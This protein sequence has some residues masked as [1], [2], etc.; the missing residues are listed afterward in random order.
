MRTAGNP[1]VLQTAL[2]VE[3]GS[4]RFQGDDAVSPFHAGNFSKGASF[5]FGYQGWKTALFIS[6]STITWNEQRSLKRNNFKSETIQYGLMVGRALFQTEEGNRFNPYI[7]GGIAIIEFDTYTDL[8]DKNGMLYQ[9]WSDGTIRDLPEAS[10][11]QQVSGILQRDYTYESPLA[12]AQRSL[13]FPLEMGLSATLS[14]RTSLDVSWKNMFMQSD[15]LDRNTD[16]PKWDNIQQISLRLNVSLNKKTSKEATFSKSIAPA[17]DYSTVNF[18]EI[19]NA[20]EDG[21]GVSDKKDRWYGT[22]KGFPVN[23]TG[24]TSDQDQDGIVDLNDKQ[25]DTPPSTWVDEAGVARSDDWLNDHYSDSTSYFVQVLRKINRN[26]RPYPIRKFIPESSYQKWTVLLEE[27]PDWRTR[28]AEGMAEFP[29]ELRRI[30]LNKDSFISLNELE[31]AVNDLFD[32]KNGMTRELL[33]KAMQ[34][35]FRDQ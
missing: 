17:V 35:A 23:E 3:I 10:F 19:W 31:Q 6:Q 9:Y 22:P 34:Y 18:E 30:D 29:S 8:Q 14:G 25:I 32:S 12:I 11:N 28:S 15:N 33:T 20:D 7:L 27:H 5:R 21:D 16:T 26:S 4:I 1:A 13:C 2:S 24:C